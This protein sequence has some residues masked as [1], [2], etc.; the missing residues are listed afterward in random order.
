MDM[1]LKDKLVVITGSTGD[2]IGRFIAQQV[3]AQGAF[4]VINGRRQDTITSSIQ[5]IS[6]ATQAASDHLIGVTGD[7]SSELGVAAFIRD[8]ERVELELGTPVYGLVNNVG[9]FHS[10][11]FFQVPDSKWMEYYQI[12]T[13]S[14]VRLCRHFLQKML[15]RNSGRVLFVSSEC[16]LRPLPHMLAYSVSKTSQISL[17]RG[18]AEMTKGSAVTVNSLLPGPTMTGGVRSYMSDFGEQSGVS[19]L[20]EAVARYFSE[21]ETTSLLQRFLDPV[22]VANVAV[23]LLSPLASGIN[24]TA[25]HVDGG[26]VRHL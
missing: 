18:L 21:H 20:D 1:Q 24:G 6:R 15:S 11:D 13:M 7:V 19:N 22:E 25:Q 5:E 4:V 3:A 26:I 2:G 23:F 14:G 12:N 8:I 9:I 16:G 10:Q 17:A